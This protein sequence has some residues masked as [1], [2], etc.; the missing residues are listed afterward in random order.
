MMAAGAFGQYIDIQIQDDLNCDITIKNAH[1]SSG[2]FYT[3]G[4]RR[5]VVSPSD[6]D[7][8]T[9]RHNGGRRNI[10][11]CGEL[12]SISETRGMFDLYDDKRATRICTLYWSASVEPERRN[13]ILKFNHDVRYDVGIGNWNESGTMGMIQVTITEQA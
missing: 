1:I 7:D 3:H 4:V 12:G 6:V 13:E 11:A 10:Y 5:D 2:Q 8:L 9:I